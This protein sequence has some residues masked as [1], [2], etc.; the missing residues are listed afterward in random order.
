M[1]DLLTFTERYIEPL[2][3]YLVYHMLKIV[4][5]QVKL[6]DDTCEKLLKLGRMGET[7]D[8]VVKK[9]IEAYEEKLAREKSRK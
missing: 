7:F 1:K 5:R 4:T 2:G 3:L 9:C 6:K 8:D